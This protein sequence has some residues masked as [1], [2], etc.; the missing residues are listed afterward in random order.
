MG[1][2]TKSSSRADGKY[3]ENIAVTY[4]KNQGYDI[5]MQNFYCKFGEIDIIG[6]NENYIC[7][8]EVKYR[9]HTKSGYAV[10]AVNK[11]KQLNIIKVANYYLLKHQ[12]VTDF[13]IRFDVVAIDN[14]DISLIKNAFGGL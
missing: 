7:F 9:K 10:E 13:P 6:Y 4:L 2:N 12:I 8:I 3:Y 1:Y 11:K 14:N 5:I